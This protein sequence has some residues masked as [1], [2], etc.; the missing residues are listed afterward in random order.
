M[1]LIE[2]ILKEYYQSWNDGFKTK[3]DSKIRSFMSSSFTGYWAFSDIEKPEVY[4]YHYDIINVLNQYDGN[5]IKE[6][7][8]I[9][10]IERKEGKNF[11]IIGTETSKITGAIHSAKCMYVWRLEND[12]WKLVREY[13]EMEN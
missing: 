5:T 3:D 13:I 12:K 4:D 10:K 8:V 7:N 11:L 6:F 2:E 9:S 1:R